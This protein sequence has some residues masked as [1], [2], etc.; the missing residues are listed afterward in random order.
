MRVLSGSTNDSSRMARPYLGDDTAVALPHVVAVALVV[1]P[2][3]HLLAVGAQVE[4]QSKVRKPFIIFRLQTLEPSAVESGSS[5]GQAAVKLR[6]SWGHTGVKLESSSG[7]ARV[8]LGSSLGQ[9]W[10]KLGSS[11]GQ[12]WVKLGS[13]L[14]QAWV[15]LHRPALSPPPVTTMSPAA[16][17]SRELISAE[18]EPSRIRI[19]CPSNASHHVTVQKGQ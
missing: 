19:A 10:V 15:K 7:Q 14:G 3:L 6:S 18:S 13:S 16:D 12:A 4:I 2:D 17:T 1:P 5:C 8:S 9:A 11:L